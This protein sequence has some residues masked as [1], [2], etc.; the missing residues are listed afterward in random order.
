M[1]IYKYS[2]W[3]KTITDWNAIPPDVTQGEQSSLKKTDGSSDVI[4]WSVFL[5]GPI[6][7]YYMF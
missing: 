3:P 6:H 4:R 7:L 2:F 1:D 5:A